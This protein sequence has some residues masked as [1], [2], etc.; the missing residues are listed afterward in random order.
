MA[1]ACAVA[2]L[3]ECGASG[4]LVLWDVRESVRL[5]GLRSSLWSVH[6]GWHLTANLELARTR[7]IRLSN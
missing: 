7:G 6:F 4:G 3:C 1:L 2:R 5:R